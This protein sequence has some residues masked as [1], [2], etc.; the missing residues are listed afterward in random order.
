MHIESKFL[1]LTGQHIVSEIIE[2]E[3]RLK[4]TRVICHSF[5]ISHYWIKDIAWRRGWQFIIEDPVGAARRVLRNWHRLLESD[6]EIAGMVFDTPSGPGSRRF[7]ELAR[8]AACGVSDVWYAWLALTMLLAGCRK[9]ARR[10]LGSTALWPVLALATGLAIHGI[11][12]SQPRYTVIYQCFWAALAAQLWRPW[13]VG[14]QQ[15]SAGCD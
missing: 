3:I 9:Q 11:F 4:R 13:L 6:H 15:A 1:T 5:L 8:S 14:P 12:E 7:Y 2:A 10:S